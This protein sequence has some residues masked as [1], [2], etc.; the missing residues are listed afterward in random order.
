MSSWM[1][2]ASAAVLAAAVCFF[3]YRAA[4]ALLVFSC[5]KIGRAPKNSRVKNEWVSPRN[6]EHTFAA[7]TKRGFTSLFPEE[8]ASRRLP[9]KPVLLAFM[10]GY[11]SFYTEVFPLLQKYNLKA[12]VFLAQEYAGTF[13]AWQNP[14]EEPWQNLLTEKQ[15]KELSKSGLVR[16]GA[17]GLKAEDVTLL[18][19]QEARFS[20]D[21]NIFRLKKQ[22]GI[23]AEAFAF[24]PAEKWDEKSAPETLRGLKVSAVLTPVPGVNPPPVKRPVYLKTL[25]PGSLRARAEVW[26]RR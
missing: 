11:Q 5:G 9:A 24:W 20:A 14:Y 21:E 17:L 22:L 26:F 25:R 8:L 10:G 18:P 3:K 19:P 1:Y 12:C 15:I 16:F 7:L 23:E 13:N 4:R 6:L 2:A